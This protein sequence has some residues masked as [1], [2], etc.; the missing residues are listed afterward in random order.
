[1]TPYGSLE[2]EAGKKKK[3]QFSNGQYKTL[4]ALISH[5]EICIWTGLNAGSGYRFKNV[6]VN[7]GHVK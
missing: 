6:S 3:N 5:K 7:S 1:V 2:I 4:T